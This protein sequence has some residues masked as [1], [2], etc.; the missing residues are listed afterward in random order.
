MALTRVAVERLQAARDYEE[1]LESLALL[2]PTM[3]DAEL[4]TVRL[5]PFSYQS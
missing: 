1:A 2:Y 3:D 5:N 4:T